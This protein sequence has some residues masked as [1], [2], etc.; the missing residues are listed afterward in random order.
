MG[1]L[2]SGK[3]FAT[4][5]SCLN[6]QTEHR[7]LP[8]VIEAEIV[9][10]LT[11]AVGEKATVYA[12]LLEGVRTRL[13]HR[14]SAFVT[15]FSTEQDD[16]GQWRGYGGGSCGF[17]IGFDAPR[18]V[19]GP[20]AARPQSAI[21]RMRYDEAEHRMLATRIVDQLARLAE[22]RRAVRSEAF[23]QEYRDF[24][25]WVVAVVKHPKFASE[26]EYRFNVT[27]KLIMDR[28]TQRI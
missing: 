12:S 8:K 11:N 19:E 21:M 23:W 4:H 7:H 22:D 26:N 25:E 13:P 18:L 3:L 9:N 2:R 15:C 14:E 27:N 10:R 16:L 1:I 6:D 17:A 5:V 28:L 24:V 20:I